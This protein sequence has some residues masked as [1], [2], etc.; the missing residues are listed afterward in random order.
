MGREL[1]GHIRKWGLIGKIHKRNHLV[2]VVV[3]VLKI[4][5]EKGYHDNGIL[6]NLI[7]YQK[8]ISS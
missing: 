2:Y 5:L 6:I 3:L 8:N 4:C 7:N 1:C